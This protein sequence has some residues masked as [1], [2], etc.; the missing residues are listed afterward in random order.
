ML[1]RRQVFLHD[2][3]GTQQERISIWWK[4]RNFQGICRIMTTVANQQQ[5]TINCVERLEIILHIFSI[6]WVSDS[7]GHWSEHIHVFAPWWDQCESQEIMRPKPFLIRQ[8]P[9]PNCPMIDHC[10]I[11]YLGLLKRTWCIIETCIMYPSVSILDYSK[12]LKRKIFDIY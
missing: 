4:A 11:I 12:V 6:S 7:A 9:K 1:R 10:P 2:S 8:F 3:N 5:C